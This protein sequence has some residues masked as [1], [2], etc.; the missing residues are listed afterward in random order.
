MTSGACN[1]ESD[2]GR[3]NGRN[4]TRYEGESTTRS[5]PAKRGSSNDPGDSFRLNDLPLSRRAS[6]HSRRC[7]R[8]NGKLHLRS[9]FDWRRRNHPAFGSGLW[10]QHD[11]TGRT[12]RSC[13]PSGNEG[14]QLLGADTRTRKGVGADPGALKLRRAHTGKLRLAGQFGGPGTVAPTVLRGRFLRRSR[15]RRARRRCDCW[16]C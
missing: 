3:T 4:P 13:C 10:I 8:P 7:R 14:S 12:A 6:L 9:R 5:P 16:C 2:A 11:I 15:G 1:N